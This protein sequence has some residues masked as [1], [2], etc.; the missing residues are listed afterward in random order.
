M[1][2]VGLEFEIC[3]LLFVKMWVMHM[4]GFVCVDV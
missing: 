1:N 4:G 2:S 3:V